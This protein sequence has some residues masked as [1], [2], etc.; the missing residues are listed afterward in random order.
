MNKIK[1]FLPF[2]GLVFTQ[3]ASVTALMA[4]L[5][6]ALF[7][8][9]PDADQSF[10]LYVLHLLLLLPFILVMTPAGHISD[11]HPKERVLFVISLILLPLSLLVCFSFYEGLIHLAYVFAFL[12]FTV[13][14]FLSPAKY[15]FLKEL[16]GVRYISSGTALLTVFSIVSIAAVGLS[17][18]YFFHRFVPQLA[19]AP[20]EVL[21]GVFPI[22]ISIFVF[23][24]GSVFFS[25][26][27]PEIGRTAS[28]D[29]KSV[30]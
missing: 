1:G 21:N 18:S 13:H 14:A 27:L 30:V 26:Y 15:G 23:S 24:L 22:S 29:R 25:R 12:F 3:I 8:I 17:T 7:R 4:L 10:K 9:S 6:L 2:F 20:Q 28:E 5:Q 19:V 11:K 16:V